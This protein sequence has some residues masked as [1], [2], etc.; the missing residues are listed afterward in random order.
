MRDSVEQLT[1]PSGEGYRRADPLPARVGG[2]FVRETTLEI[3]TYV[4]GQEDRNPPLYNPDALRADSEYPSLF[5]SNVYPYTRQTNLTEDKVVKT[6][7]AVILENDYIQVI[8]LPDMGG[9][10]YAAHDKT[11]DNADFIYRNHAVKPGLIA[12]RGA[13][14]S[15]GVE[16]NF[17]TRGHTTNTISPVQYKIIQSENGSVTC[18]VGTTEW[19][20]RMRWL[21]A[22]TV[23]PDRSYFRSRILLSNQTLTH[24][25]AY[26]WTNSAVHAWPDTRVTLPPTHYTYAGMRRNPEPWPVNGGLDVSWAKNTQHHCDYFCGVPG[27]YIGA[28]HHERDCG[29]A[30]FAAEQ[31]SPGKK[32]WTFGTAR[33]GT[34]WEDILT[35]TDGEFLELQSGRLLTQGDSWIFEPHWQ[36]S[37]EGYWYPLKEMKGLVKL[38]CEAAINFSLHD[39]KLLL[40]LNT[41]T[42]F[43]DATLRLLVGSNEV[44]SETVTIGPGEFWQRQIAT[45]SNAKTCRLIFQDHNG[46]EIITYC[47]EEEEKDLPPPEVEP[48]LPSGEMASAEETYLDGYYALKHWS[49]IRA[50]KRFED[51]LKKDPGFTPALRGLAI[52]CYKTGR[53]NEA[54][55]L[56]TR[57]LHRNDDDHAARYYRALSKIKLGIEE[58]TEEDL[59]LVGRR[60][61]FRHVAPYVLAS[62]AVTRNDFSRAEELL[63]QAIHHNPKDLKARAMLAS[64]LR[65]HGRPEEALEQ[66]HGVLAEDPINCL[67][68]VEQVLLGGEGELALLKDDPQYYLEAAWDYA[69]MNLQEDAAAALKLY[70]GRPGAAKHPFVC[71]FLGY[72]ADE[73]NDDNLARTYYGLGTSLPVDYVFPFRTESLAVLNTGLRYMPGN[74]K[75]HYYLGTLLTAHFRWK[76]G[77]DHLL[78]AQ[79]ASPKCSVLYRNVGEIY[80]KKL[81]DL[82]NAQAAY[83]KALECDPGDFSYY[84]A[85][86]CLYREVGGNEKRERLFAEAPPTV[87]KDFRVLFAQAGYYADVG[88]VDE[89]L[90]IL[91]HNTFHPWEGWTKVWKLYNRVLHLRADKHMKHGEY[92]EAM[93]DLRQATEYP[94]NLGTGR[95]HNPNYVREHYKLGLCHKCLGKNAQA[96]EYFAKA[97]SCSRGH[98]QDDS[99]WHDRAVAEL[100]KLREV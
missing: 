73:S 4:L 95:P 28:Y 100:R 60:V 99:D 96:R 64:V 79:A 15:G 82:E 41:T 31:E 32:F 88:R 2:A 42:E 11:N 13:W 43:R 75:L 33:D 67:G 61:D 90:Q 53:F 6:Y 22:T 78:L 66:V 37:W 81:N 69:Q 49:P 5:D 51:A 94:E 74:W 8:I 76:E 86:D 26:F 27:G 56:C 62:L 71:F 77:L 3:P 16:W 36:E 84:V 30:H 7:R 59:I 34:I 12:L 25:N 65:R 55:E 20:Q 93:E 50:I 57:A 19:V 44:F 83:E 68:I 35:D 72:L 97:A 89:A 54:Y 23:Y 63:R 29:T 10:I 38:N 91:R 1:T 98:L 70:E 45:P 24:N 87:A 58:R 21:V 80:W 52:I 48:E 39:G 85:L 47:P 14:L 92:D 40:A 18:V 46:R 9:K 17:P